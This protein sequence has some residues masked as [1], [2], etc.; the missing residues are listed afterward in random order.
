MNVL[1]IGCGRTGSRL[2]NELNERGVDVIVLDIDESKKNSLS[3]DFSGMYFCGDATDPDVLREASCENA[4]AVVVVTDNDNINVMV[5]QLVKFEFDIEKIFV[6]VL[7]PSREKVFESFGLRTI[8]PTRLEKNILFNLLTEEKTDMDSVD[9]N[10]TSIR[11]SLEK[12]NKKQI[13]TFCKDIPTKNSVMVFG[14]QKPSGK[15]LLYNEELVIEERDL[16]IYA[17]V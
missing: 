14:L 12:P 13:N 17:S 10:G 1:I 8:C 16:I 7:D 5:A 6:R 15:V 11:F 2:A 9:L 4:D 3:L